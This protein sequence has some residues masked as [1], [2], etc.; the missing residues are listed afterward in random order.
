MQKVYVLSTHIIRYISLQ[1]VQKNEKNDLQSSI[2][3]FSKRLGTKVTAI[4]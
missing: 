3:S 2:S 1:D 4:G